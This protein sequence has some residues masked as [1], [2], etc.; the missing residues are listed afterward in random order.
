MKKSWIEKMDCE[1][2]FKIK[3]IDKNFADIPKGSRM[4]TASPLIIDKSVKLILYGE[5]N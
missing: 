4:L 2:S 3:I 5:I 1:K